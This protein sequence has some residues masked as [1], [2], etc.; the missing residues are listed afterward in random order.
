[1]LNKTQTPNYDISEID[2]LFFKIYGFYP[3]KEGQSYE[4]IVGSILKILSR[5]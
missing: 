3:T 1:M 5:P 2:E 4:L